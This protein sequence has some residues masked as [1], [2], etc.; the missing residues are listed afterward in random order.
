MSSSVREL[1]LDKSDQERINRYSYLI[2]RRNQLQAT[3]TAAQRERENQRD[4]HTDLEEAELL[5]EVERVPVKVGHAF[6]HVPVDVAL[7]H[8]GRLLKHADEEA[9][10][11]K[12]DLER[13]EKE[14]QVL[15]N[16][17]HSKFGNAI[18]LE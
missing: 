3:L 2:S 5:G 6:L 14:M 4:A 9:S 1:T 15:K 7:A 11:S 17:L 10:T 18:R 8:N 13:T 12:A 16:I